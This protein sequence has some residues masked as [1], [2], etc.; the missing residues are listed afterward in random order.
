MYKRYVRG[1]IFHEMNLFHSVVPFKQ[2][3]DARYHHNC[4]RNT[5]PTLAS[6]VSTFTLFVANHAVV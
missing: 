4:Y 1:K 5:H 3:D 6:N 2:N